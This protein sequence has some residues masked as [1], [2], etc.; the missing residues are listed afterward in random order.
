MIVSYFS[1]LELEFHSVSTLSSQVSPFVLEFVF[2]GLASDVWNSSFWMI[3][4]SCVMLNG[5]ISF[6]F[7][8][9]LP[10]HGNTVKHAQ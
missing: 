5:P 2:D 4:V 3:L 1:S 6:P 9:V 10:M 7:Y 8:P